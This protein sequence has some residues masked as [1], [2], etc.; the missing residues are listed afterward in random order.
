VTPGTVAAIAAV[1]KAVGETREASPGECLAAV[2]HELGFL[3]AFL[4]DRGEHE[5][6][7]ATLVNVSANAGGDAYRE[8]T[9]GTESDPNAN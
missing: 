3:L 5:D 6:D 4:A 2:A 9:Q 8:A 1:R 7:L